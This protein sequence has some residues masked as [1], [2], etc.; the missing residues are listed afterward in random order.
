MTIK[1]YD[2]NKITSSHSNVK[3]IT[4]S[5]SLCGSRKLILTFNDNTQ[6]I[7]HIKAWEIFGIW[8]D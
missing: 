7:V 6:T 2:G 4:T 5:S 8:Q 3:H 1:C